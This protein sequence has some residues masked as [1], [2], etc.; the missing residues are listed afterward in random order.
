MFKGFS[1][2]FIMPCRVSTE[3]PRALITWHQE[4]RYRE[5]K[6]QTF[7]EAREKEASGQWKK[8]KKK[9][10]AAKWKE[11]LISPQLWQQEKE[12]KNIFKNELKKT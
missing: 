5:R 8:K 4:Y 2:H 7:S 12:E 9:S 6:I 1:A 10:L 3:P 11:C